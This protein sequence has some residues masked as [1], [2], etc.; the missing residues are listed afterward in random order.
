MGSSAAAVCSGDIV[1]DCHVKL[2]PEYGVIHL[3]NALNEQGQQQLWNLMKPRI[4]D[5]SN[6]ATGFQTFVVCAEDH[7]NRKRVKRVP[8]VDAFGKLLFTLCA[9]ALST[10]L[11]V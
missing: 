3:K 4:C 6:K 11:G 10:T 2:V 8:E 5:P 7:R 9:D 1:G